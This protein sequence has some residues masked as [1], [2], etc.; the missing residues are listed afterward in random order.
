MVRL[1]GKSTS[2]TESLSMQNQTSTFRQGKSDWMI[3]DGLKSEAEDLIT[4]LQA[5]FTRYKSFT[6]QNADLL[7]YL[8]FEDTTYFEAFRVPDSTDDMTQVGKK[9]RA[10]DATYLLNQWLNGW[11]AGLYKKHSHVIDNPAIWEMLRPDRQ[12]KYTTWKD[13]LFEEQV[14]E[15]RD[16]AKQYN[17]CQN[18]LA[19]KFSEK[20]TAILRSKRIIGCTTTAAAK[21]S[22]TIQAAAPNVLLVEEAGEILESH[23]LTALGKD[24]DQLIL[25]GDHKYVAPSLVELI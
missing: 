10:V 7:D 4:K 17:Q 9:G 20:S 15:F 25:I 6:V 3:I 16:L 11:D 23:V 22:D 5:A 14:T 12:A 8:E 13:A 19:R 24:K 21:Y 2:R 1:G 18:E